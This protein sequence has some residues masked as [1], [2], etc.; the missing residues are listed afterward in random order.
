MKLTVLEPHGG[1]HKMSVAIRS[2]LADITAAEPVALSCECDIDSLSRAILT[3]SEK[4]DIL[5]VVGQM[6]NGENARLAAA[7]AFGVS[8]KMSK[9]AAAHIK[10]TCERLREDAA[11]FSNCAL[12]PENAM[13]VVGE[14]IIPACFCVSEERVILLFDEQKDTELLTQLSAMITAICAENEVE[15]AV[16][17]PTAQPE[18]IDFDTPYSN[19]LIFAAARAAEPK[20][21]ANSIANDAA[22]NAEQQKRQFAAAASKKIKKKSAPKGGGRRRKITLPF[23][24]K[25]MRGAII[26]CAAISIVMIFA[27]IMGLVSSK[28]EEKPLEEPPMQSSISVSEPKK[29]KKEREEYVYNGED[30]DIGEDEEPEKE[31]KEKSQAASAEPA[32]S[33]PEQVSEAVSK[34]PQ[35]SQAAESQAPVSQPEPQSQPEP[36]SQP[37]P[38]QSQPPQTVT[39]VVSQAEPPAPV[40]SSEPEPEKPEREEYVYNG[41]DDDAGEDEEEQEEQDEQDDEDDNDEITRYNRLPKADDDAFDEKLTYITNGKRYKMNAYDLVCQILQNETRGLF[42]EEALKAHAVATYSMIKYNNARGL[43]PSVL[44]KSNVSDAVEDAVSEVLGV[45]VYYNNSFANTVYHS[46]SSGNTT[47]SQSVWGGALPYLVSVKSKDDSNS[48]YYKASYKISSSQLAKRIEKTYGIDVSGDP[49]DWI[50]IEHD[51]PGGY[52]GTVIID[53]ETRAQ[54]GTMGNAKITG[55]SVREN[56]LSFA[57]RSHCF[58]LEYDDD[59]DEFIFTSYGYG[60]GV[61]MSQYGAHYMA[62]RGYNFVEILHH[63]YPNTEIY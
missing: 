47:S 25:E 5:I 56:L 60:H 48:P 21:A 37:E 1:S 46:T 4:A 20:Q 15:Q 51:A 8:L 27:L 43:A 19:D 3:E 54:G 17:P 6:K 10:T 44:L 42:D 24:I 7:N 28:D 38:Q 57:I 40:Q 12:L 58:D 50:E 52:V 9:K 16:E 23:R 55:R 2:M 45:A 29:A 36:I 14:G 30:D 13:A 62:Q 32:P 34:A 33:K 35:Q 11:A 49:E 39:V 26:G 61:G 22:Q 63:Y 31:Q 53:G 59:D 18:P 41:E